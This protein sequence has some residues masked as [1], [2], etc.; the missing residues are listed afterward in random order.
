VKNIKKSTTILILLFLLVSFSYSIELSFK[1]SGGLNYLNLKSVN[2]SLQNWS[3]YWENKAQL[4]EKWSFEGEV[5]EFHV[6][7][8]FEGEIM[9]A[10]TPHFAVSLGS[11]YIYGEITEE[12]TEITVK[13][14]EI[15]DIRVRPNKVSAYPLKISGYFFL[16]FQK[17]F[18]F[19]LKGGTGLLW[20]KYINWEGYRK[21]PKTEFNFSSQ[22]AKAKGPG[23]EGGIGFAVMIDSHLRLFIEGTARY[24]KI[25]GFKG[26]MKTGERGTLFFFE[27]YD[28]KLNLWEPE[29]EILA[30]EPKGEEFRSVQEAVV[31][32]SG[33][34]VKM[35]III[36]F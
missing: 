30:E 9:I 11:G 14:E 1:F 2:R 19:Y 4:K 23:F 34:S 6:G 35:G 36:K 29:V 28:S 25:G 13:R 12:K 33:F 22:I 3:G 16:P 21:L 17:K 26:E 8:D 24:A 15:T 10:L 31:D 7:F 20:A 5:K 18:T 27:T 32:F